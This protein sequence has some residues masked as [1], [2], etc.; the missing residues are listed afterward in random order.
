MGLLLHNIKKN[1]RYPCDIYIWLFE[2]QELS[3]ICT[4]HIKFCTALDCEHTV[5]TILFEYYLFQTH[6]SD[7]ANY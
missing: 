6:S 3:T 1:K 4:M 2:G 5:S 7:R